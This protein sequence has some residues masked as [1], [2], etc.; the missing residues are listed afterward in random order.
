MSNSETHGRE[1]ERDRASK[2]LNITE[3]FTRNIFKKNGQCVRKGISRVSLFH[4]TNNIVRNQLTTTWFNSV[5]Y[6]D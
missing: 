1:R 3:L 2:L 5:F 4:G 6:T